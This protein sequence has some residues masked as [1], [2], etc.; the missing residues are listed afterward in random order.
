MH[1]VK[2]RQLPGCVFSKEGEAKYDRSFEHFAK[3]VMEK[4]V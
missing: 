1:H 3:L 2:N 4:K